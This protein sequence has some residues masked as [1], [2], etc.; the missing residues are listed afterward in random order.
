MF[1]D[2]P[3]H[4]GKKRGGL[5]KKSKKERASVGKTVK[6]A[7]DPEAKRER[8]PEADAPPGARR[9]WWRHDWVVLGAILLLGLSLRLWYLSNA[10][11]APDFSAPQ[12]DPAVQ[13]WYARALVT[14]DWTLPPLA[15]GHP[16][17]GTTPYFRPPGHGYSLAVIYFFTNGSYLAPRIVNIALGLAG[18]VLVFL[19]GRSVYGRGV[20]LI[21]AFLVATYWV[22]IFWEGEVNDPSLFVFLVPLLMHWLRR[23]AGKMTF[24]R[25]ALVGVTT[26]CYALMRPNILLFGPVMAAWML[27]VA[28][29]RGRLRA[30]VPSWCALA[31]CTFAV[32]APVT[33]RNYVVSGGEFVPISTYFG[34]NLVIGN[35]EDSDGVTP[36]LPYLQE[37]E[38]TGMWSVWVYDNVVKGLGKELGI[39]DIT[40]SEASSRFTRKAVAFI[41]AHKLHTLKMMAKKAVLFWTPVEITCNKVVQYEKEWYPPL[42]YLP[43]FAMA[44]ALW[45]FGTAM[46]VVDLKGRRVLGHAATEGATNTEMSLLLFAFLFMY[47]ASFLMFFVNGRA[48]VP[49]IPV[50][51]LVGAYGVYRAG[52][53]AAARDYRRTGLCV[54]AFALLWVLG[55]I[56]YIDFEPDRA[57]WYY[58]RAESYLRRGMVDE[59]LAEAD[60]LLDEPD[61]PSYMNMR[62]GR[63]FA[64]EGREERAFL[65]FMAALRD[66]PADLDVQ[67]SGAVELIKIGKIEEGIRHYHESIALDPRD[68]RAHNN[69]GLLLAE[70]GQYAEAVKHFRAAIQGDPEFVLAYNNLGNLLGRLG[71]YEDAV[72]HF[73][74]AIKLKPDEQDFHY[75]LAVHLANA[76]RT[77]EA[78]ERYRVALGLNPA[79][80]RAHNNL[81]LILAG[82]GQPDEA[83]R[84]YE[85]ALRVVP[86]FVLVYANWGNLLADQ[87][88]FDAAVAMYEKGLAMA[89]E[90]AGLH[91]G[92]GFLYARAGNAQEAVGHYLEALRIAPDYPLAH[93]NL[94]NALAAQGKIDDAVAHYRRALEIDPRDKY[95]HFN[96]GNLFWEQDDPDQAIAHFLQALENDP[97]NADVPNNLANALVRKVRFDEAVRYY[98]LALRINPDYANA[99][100]NLGQVL[101]A[102]KRYDQAVEHF[103]RVIEI[104]PDYPN[105]RQS[106][107]KAQAERRKQR[108]ATGL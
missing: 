19:L 69:L 78:V 65:H 55:S 82:R 3:R 79:D 7:A 71:R 91:N 16:N 44:L 81:G 90:D 29:R 99:H 8:T 36:W 53:F 56:E 101:D 27:W 72:V 103:R 70:Q 4:L 102:L 98:Q 14:G 62:L 85:E 107:D 89:P 77:D 15:E 1:D 92:L 108:E 66:Y 52:Q 32:I 68:A 28:W 23:W 25:A 13:D 61:V 47:F 50:M 100:F 94:G 38:G 97:T 41:R 20:G 73:T 104:D 57:R 60:H 6:P 84:H 30:V 64:A 67:L 74:E 2:P 48:R 31:L 96:L 21:A 45:V 51:L 95:A 42:K 37:L 26:G 76:G 33:I 80:A 46:L 106:L 54:G 10:V 43:G 83:V 63:W 17:M 18:V 40:H 11:H 49:I 59:A 35:N 39:E 105:A 58:Q 75:N 87:G 88:D 86:D 9:P 12:Q 5:A 24:R 34:E 22:F 93:N